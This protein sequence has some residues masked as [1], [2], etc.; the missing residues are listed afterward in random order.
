MSIINNRKNKFWWRCGWKGTL[1]H[2]CWECKLAQLLWKAVWRFL[3]K[4]KI[5]VLYE[6]VTQ[7]PGIYLKEC[8]AG[9]NRATAHSC[10]LQHFSQWPSFGN[11]P[12]APKLE[13]IKKIWYIYMIE[14]YTATKKNEF[15]LCAGKWMEL[16]NM[17]SKV[18]QIQKDKD[19][20]FSLICG[21]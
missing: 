16:E 6:P 21:S 20:M 8:K 12:D 5:E 17:L 11:S 19:H 1:I 14:Y 18:N 7:L 9:C 10:L 4:L 13:W 2:C 3:I 15:M